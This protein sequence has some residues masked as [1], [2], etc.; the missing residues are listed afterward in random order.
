MI[1]KRSI[2]RDWDNK[3]R[4]V[5]SLP[6]R[7]IFIFLAGTFL[8]KPKDYDNWIAKIAAE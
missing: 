2:D 1:D 8:S 7:S 3:T 6:Q 4:N 5:K